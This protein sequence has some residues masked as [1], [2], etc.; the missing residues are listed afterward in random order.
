MKKIAVVL[1][2][3]ITALGNAQTWVTNIEEAKTLAAKE[4]KTILLVFSG[5]DWCAPCMKLEKVVWKSEEFK[6]EAENKWILLRADFPKKKGNQLSAELTASNK[7]LAEKY[8]KGGNFPLVVMLD[9]TGKVIGM[10][11]FKN[12]TAEE[13]IKMI[14]SLVK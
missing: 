11:G 7:K 1:L 13:Y 6:Q 9:K 12:V 10:T 3:F 14:N 4:N 5:S 8:N 2:F